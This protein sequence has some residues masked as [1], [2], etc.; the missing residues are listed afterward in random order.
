MTYFRQ[1]LVLTLFTT[2]TGCISLYDYRGYQEFDLIE[3]IHPKVSTREHVLANIGSP[4]LISQ[5]GPLTYYFAGQKVRNTAFLRPKIVEQKVAAITF[6][7]NHK[8]ESVRIYTLQDGKPNL[9]FDRNYTKTRGDDTG[10]IIDTFGN[11][12]KFNVDN[13]RR[14]GRS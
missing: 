12:G 5:Y 8:V 10:F 1:F 14:A 4:T 6:A 3:Q 9:V 11:V 7:A 2:L 13:G